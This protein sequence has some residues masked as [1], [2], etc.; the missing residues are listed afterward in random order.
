MGRVP[1][2]SPVKVSTVAYC[3]YWGNRSPE[4]PR[5]FSQSD[6]SDPEVSRKAPLELFARREECKTL[7][8]AFLAAE[9][10]YTDSPDIEI[11]GAG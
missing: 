5:N 10:W 4:T 7:V 3:V 6:N 9:G 2:F 1:R 11:D 8:K